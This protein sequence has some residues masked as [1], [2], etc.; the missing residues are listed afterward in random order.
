MVSPLGWLSRWPGAVLT[1]LAVVG[2]AAGVVVGLWSGP[3]WLDE[4]LSVEI[5]SLPLSEFYQALRQDGSPPLYYLV[6]HLWMLVLGSSEEAVRGLSLLFG[7]LWDGGGPRLARRARA[8]P[9]RAH[10]L[11]QRRGLRRPD[12]RAAPS[13]EEVQS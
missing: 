3:L 1:A 13:P 9:R 10:R 2:C 6:L 7:L 12:G 5:A 4:A 8:H 11:P